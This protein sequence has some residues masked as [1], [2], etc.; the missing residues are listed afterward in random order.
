MWEEKKAPPITCKNNSKNKQKCKSCHSVLQMSKWV[1][2]QVDDVPGDAKPS[3]AGHQRW[4][5]P[6]MAR[7][8]R[9]SRRG[10][11]AKQQGQA[12]WWQNLGWRHP[13]P[14]LYP[15]G[16]CAKAGQAAGAGEW[17]HP[18]SC[19]WLCFAPLLA[20]WITELLLWEA[21][22]E[23]W[24]PWSWVSVNSCRDKNTKDEHPLWIRPWD[25]SYPCVEGKSCASGHAAGSTTPACP[26]FHFVASNQYLM[27]IV[28]Q[29]ASRFVHWD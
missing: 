19:S 10:G 6:H 22:E 3:C 28:L 27:R 21:E 29:D 17:P 23:E 8:G 26:K 16:A 13:S 11:D 18:S 9:A 7:L 25:K 14:E 20:R 15:L 2:S 24:A 1:G 5:P 4:S 12:D